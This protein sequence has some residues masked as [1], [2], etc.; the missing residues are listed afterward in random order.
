M[1][2]SNLEQYVEKTNSWTKLFNGKEL[3][4]LIAEDRQRIA[5][6]L[7]GDLSPENLTMDGEASPSYVRQRYQFL[8]RCVAELRSIDP[9][10]VLYEG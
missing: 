3:S 5:D 9:T 4:L 8:T 1:N 10:V 6:R 2:I 7:D